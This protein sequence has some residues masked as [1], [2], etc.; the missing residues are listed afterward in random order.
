MFILKL[1]RVLGWFI[2]FGALA[3]YALKYPD[4]S[5]YIFSR[6]T[7]YLHLVLGAHLDLLSRYIEL[8][9]SIDEGKK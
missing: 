8:K 9:K 2:G 4:Y 7:L 1:V 6:D 3:A 5:T